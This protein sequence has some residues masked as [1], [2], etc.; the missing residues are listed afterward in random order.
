MQ[1]K[2]IFKL[3]SSSLISLMLTA[4]GGGGNGSALDNIL[5][6]ASSSLNGSS[7]SNSSGGTGSSNSSSSSSSIAIWRLGV[8]TGVNF[9][10]TK[11]EFGDNF[12]AIFSN[13]TTTISVDIVDDLGVAVTETVPVTFSS[14]CIKA[15]T[16]TITG[17]NTT[18]S[19]NGK[20]KVEY[21]AGTCFGDD[22]ID[23]SISHAGKSIT[24]S[25]T[26]PQINN[27]RIGSDV[28]QN[29]T[30]SQITLPTDIKTLFEGDTTQLSVNI[31]DNKNSLVNQA[32]QVT[33]ESPC[34]NAGLSSIVGGNIVNSTSGVAKAQYKVGKC[35]LD[36]T[37]TATI[38]NG[39]FSA[40]AEATLAIDNRRLGSGFGDNFIIGALEL[41]I[42]SGVL[43]PGGS[44]T[45]TAYLVNS[46]G[47]LAAD[48]DI[49]V[50]FS[51]PCL[52]SDNASITDGKTVKAI[53]GKAV[54]TYTSKGCAGIAGVD[55]I[56][57]TAVVRSAV[58]SASAD[59]AIKTD[60]AQ[61]ISFTSA[62]PP[63]I[64]IKGTGGT[65]TSIVKFQ[66]LGQGGSPLKD[67]CVNFAPST[68]IGGLTLVP[69]K[70]TPAGSETYGATTDANGYVSTIV[71]SGTVAT[72]VRVT[73]TTANGLSTQS[74]ALAVSTGIPD[75]NS[76]SLS[77]TDIGPAAWEHDGVTVQAT[78]RLA[79]A[80]N[81]PVPNNTTISFTT[82]GGSINATCP[83]TDG[84]CSVTWRSQSPRPVS[85]NQVFFASTYPF[86]K[87]CPVEKDSDNV[88]VTECRSGRVKI[89]ATAIGNESF[90]DA[91]SNG[92]YDGP[93]T[94][95]FVTH[96]SSDVDANKDACNPSVP[97]SSASVGTTKGC[98]DLPEAYIDSNFN[99]HRSSNEV[100]VDFNQNGIYDTAN[101]IYDGALCFDPLSL[102]YCT[103]NKVAVR[104]DATL[105][106]SCES[107]FIQSGT[108]PGIS[109]SEILT[110]GQTKNI[111]MLLADC[112]GN[113]M[114]VGTTVNANI[115]NATNI[116]TA[117]I[118]PA[119]L[120]MSTEP[121]IINLTL[122]GDET[123]PA[124][125][126]LI[127]EVTVGG[128]TT[129]IPININQNP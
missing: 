58:L 1:T 66:V 2:T 85:P 59:L 19:V 30:P 83:T 78:I 89:L 46:K 3:I 52:S 88:D 117:S 79:D 22:D 61:T 50:T 112:N 40:S 77:L 12:E 32:T 9:V 73:A 57:A 110:L 64:S 21:K 44:T 97:N 123:K 103:S 94:D 126:T 105:V 74:S 118:T 23:A 7:G 101:G 86:N 49:N 35:N 47:D 76:M 62:S 120:A 127:I 104:D 84:A 15:G 63:L 10:P 48:D 27:K 82:N 6:G 18:N 25:G 5:N 125:G 114:P 93:V 29:F 95:I 96:K 128:L 111:K 68:S 87:I 45:V 122:T 39:S 121:S 36:D 16:S 124:K 91:N 80:F 65:E 116:K 100:P 67:V 119:K 70:C 38:V 42:G 113:G 26:I 75:Q 55:A 13:Q 34:I 41:G 106:M 51:S 20:A 81:N 11:L 71:Q 109:A 43:S 129:S 60:T 115:G 8:G 31:V 24:A 108:L 54:A 56:K 4:C 90:I 98:D 99:Y 102:G 33:F 72:P 28:G 53:N 92:L 69:S 17:G 107:P 14:Q 37:V